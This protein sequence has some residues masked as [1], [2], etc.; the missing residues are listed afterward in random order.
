LINGLVFN[1]QK[2]ICGLAK[3]FKPALFWTRKP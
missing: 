2:R 1:H 3:I